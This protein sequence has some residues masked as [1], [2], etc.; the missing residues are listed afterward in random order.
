MGKWTQ[1]LRLA[2]LKLIK[3]NNK[4]EK[5]RLYRINN[6]FTFKILRYFSGDS[7][8]YLSYSAECIYQRYLFTG[9]PAGG[10]INEIVVS[11]FNIEIRISEIP[12]LHLTLCDNI[13]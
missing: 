13:T 6:D 3:T 7:C 1:K 2:C 10:F 8:F 4:P 12:L 5:S 11:D 9:A